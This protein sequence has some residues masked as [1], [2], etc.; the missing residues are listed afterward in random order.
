[1]EPTQNGSDPTRHAQ[2]LPAPPKDRAYDARAIDLMGAYLRD[3]GRY[4]LLD[5][6]AERTLARAAQRGDA[7]ARERLVLSNLRLVVYVVRE[8]TAHGSMGSLDLVQEGNLGLLR[9]IERFDP[10]KGY[11]FSTYATWWIHHAIRRALAREGRTIRL[12]VSVLQ[13]GQRIEATERRLLD[14]T[15]APPSDQEVADAL[16]VSVERL[17]QVKAALQGAVSLEGTTAGDSGERDV[18]EFLSDETLI[19]P[20]EDALRAIWWEALQEEIT[21]L[22]P[23]QAEVFQLRYGL[24][25]GTAHTLASAGALLGISRER[26]RQLEQQALATLRKSKRLSQIARFL[27]RL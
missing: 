16:G 4:P 8:Y 2:A 5:A 21:A 20:E 9:A 11:R 26:V 3:I 14:E 17:R 15:G 22:S 27:S 18:E 13:L 23:R 24:A 1:M 6:E 19:S 25:D 10:E 12:P 7:A